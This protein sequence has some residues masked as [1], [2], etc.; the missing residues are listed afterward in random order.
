MKWKGWQQLRQNKKNGISMAVVIC[1]SAFFVAFAAAILYTAGLLTAQSNLRLKEERCNQLAT[2]A[3]KVLNEELLKY[4]NKTGD[5]SQDNTFYAFV[6][7]FLDD[8]QYLDYSEDYPDSSKYNFLVS[9]TNLDNLAEAA[10]LPAGYGNIRITLSKEKNG[11]EDLDSV[12]TGELD[13]SAA[14]T[15]YQTE[16]DR[17]RNI[18]VRDYNLTVEVTAAYDDATYTCKTE[19]SR[20]EKYDVKFSHKGTDIVWDGTNW[21]KNN[22]SGEIYTLDASENIK[23]EFVTQTT[24]SCVFRENTYMDT[25]QGGGSD[26]E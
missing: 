21:R 20:E 9:D 6:N 23:Y 19:Y 14:G 17:I 7:K 24:T 3:A 4:G 11:S 8:P 10:S 1:I 15:N 16:I 13:S 26:T 5:A 12:K 2:S 22:T 18:T 25:T